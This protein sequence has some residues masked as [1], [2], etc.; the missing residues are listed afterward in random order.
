MPKLSLVVVVV[1]DDD[2][3]EDVVVVVG[4]DAGG[5]EFGD[6]ESGVEERLLFSSSCPLP[7]LFRSS[8]AI[9]AE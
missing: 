8:A 6:I 1:D 2:E 9:L 4:A 5:G 7:S 3:E